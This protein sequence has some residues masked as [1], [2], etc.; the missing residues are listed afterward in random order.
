[1]LIFYGLVRGLVSLDVGVIGDF[2]ALIR[3]FHRAPLLWWAKVRWWLL[4]ARLTP[5]LPC[6]DRSPLPF[7]PPPSPT[8][9]PLLPPLQPQAMSATGNRNSVAMVSLLS[10][11]AMDSLPGP[12]T[13]RSGYDSEI[14]AA[15]GSRGDGSS[16]A[17]GSSTPS[18]ARGGRKHRGSNIGAGGGIIIGGPVSSAASEVRGGPVRMH[19][20]AWAVL[21]FTFAA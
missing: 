7:P 3:E 11:A 18:A 10:D 14:G 1:M 2:S 20:R 15:S 19:V 12:H 8:A 9:D 13:P 17:S 6:D 5:A 4:R 21:A 16:A